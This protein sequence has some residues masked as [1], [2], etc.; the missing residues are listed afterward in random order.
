MSSKSKLERNRCVELIPSNTAMTGRRPEA[1]R[2][3]APSLKV[4]TP[5]KK[6]TNDER[7]KNIDQTPVGEKREKYRQAKIRNAQEGDPFCFAEE[8]THPRRIV[9]PAQQELKGQ[10]F[11][12]HQL[13][14]GN[15]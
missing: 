4:Q 15:G 8:R 5:K 9:R 1:S 2:T 10:V 3:E 13:V 7:R 12:E 14:R 6:A 11:G